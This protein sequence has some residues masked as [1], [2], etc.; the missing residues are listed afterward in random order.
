MSVSIAPDDRRSYK[1]DGWAD[2][3]KRQSYVFARHGIIG[4][5][6]SLFRGR[7]ADFL[8]KLA[9]PRAC[10]AVVCVA[11]AM[12]TGARSLHEM[13]RKSL[14]QS[15]YSATPTA[16]FPWRHSTITTPRKMRLSETIVKGNRRYGF[17]RR[18][19]RAR[20]TTIQRPGLYVSGKDYA[21][22]RVLTWIWY[23]AG[24]AMLI[25]P[26]GALL[27]WLV[28]TRRDALAAEHGRDTEAYREAVASDLRRGERDVGRDDWLVNPPKP[29]HHDPCDRPR[30]GRR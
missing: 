23:L 14:L 26:L 8:G 20:G 30:F 15:S 16:E 28:R 9:T 25:V 18:H 21:I 1:R 10:F 11:L 3:V 24:W 27:G 13:H 17:Q 7:I 6:I 22:H 19:S 2:P 5:M 12:M 29:V 4:L